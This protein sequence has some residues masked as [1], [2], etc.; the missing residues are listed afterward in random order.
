M[1]QVSPIVRK[2]CL[3]DPRTN[4]FREPTLEDVTAHRV[5]VTTL[6]TSRSLYNSGLE[7][8]T[9]LIIVPNTC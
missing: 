1:F 5:V 7:P 4:T 3:V 6:S 2:Y 9:S 8:G